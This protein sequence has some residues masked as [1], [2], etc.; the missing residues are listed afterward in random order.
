MLC[1]D[2]TSELAKPGSF[3]SVE[4][5]ILSQSGWRFLNKSSGL[6]ER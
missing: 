3:G 1:V 5:Q 4:G 2:I 6:V